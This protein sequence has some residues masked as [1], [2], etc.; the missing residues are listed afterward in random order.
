MKTTASLIDAAPYHNA[1]PAS[2]DLERVILRIQIDCSAGPGGATAITM[3]FN[4]R[5][6]AKLLLQKPEQR[7][8]FDRSF[9]AA[10]LAEFVDFRVR[11]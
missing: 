2:E 3:D 5:S 1:R 11:P 7:W 8:R 9:D 4:R 10:E 6:N